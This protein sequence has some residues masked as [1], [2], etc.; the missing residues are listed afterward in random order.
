MFAHMLTCHVL[1]VYLGLVC[2]DLIYTNDSATTT[3]GVGGALINVTKVRARH[4][5]CCLS[6]L[7]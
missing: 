7:F 3:V 1:A 2:R 5:S 4:A 6:D